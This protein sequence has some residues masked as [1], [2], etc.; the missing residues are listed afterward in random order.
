MN[1]RRYRLLGALLTLALLLTSCLIALPT[2]ADAMEEC[3]AKKVQSAPEDSTVRDLREACLSETGANTVMAEKEPESQAKIRAEN[4]S[5]TELHTHSLT[6][7]KQNYVL[8]YTYASSMNPLYQEA[9]LHMDQAEAKFQFSFRFP[10]A[11]EDLFVKGDGLDL[12]YTQ[13]SLW[14]VYNSTLSEPFRETN[15]NPEIFYTMP[16]SFRPLGGYMDL[17]LAL[18]HE[19][20]GLGR[21]DGVNLSRSW[22]RVY[23][24]F[25][26]SKDNYII[27][28]RPWYRIP[29]PQNKSPTD[30]SGDDNPDIEKYMGYFDLTGALTYRKLEFS[31]LARDNLRSSNNYGALELGMS[32]P[33]FYRL[34]G[35]VQYFNGYGDTLIDYNRHVTRYGVGILFTDLL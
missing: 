28:L 13:K 34:R 3:L 14:Q 18:E 21:T 25:I 11:P 22:N 16:L 5:H 26:F 6:A 19:S 20:N 31:L 7:Y 30:F 27:A 33:L 15:Y 29:E 17:R 32:F 12:G 2:Y 9:G 4:E 8:P 10:I 35:Y 24:K 23:A 1:M